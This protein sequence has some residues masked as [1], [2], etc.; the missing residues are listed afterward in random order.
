M[1][2]MFLVLTSADYL[3]TNC[4]A[5]LISKSAV[6]EVLKGYIPLP[7]LSPLFV[8]LE[9]DISLKSC[10]VALVEEMETQTG[11]AT[12]MKLAKLLPQIDKTEIRAV[13]DKNRFMQ[14][15]RDLQGK[16]PIST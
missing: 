11:L 9:V 15:I 8:I 16:W 14:L 5:S 13:P 3:A 12:G 6:K 2:V 7:K 1:L 4:M 10:T